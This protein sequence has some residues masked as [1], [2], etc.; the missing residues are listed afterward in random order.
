LAPFI[1][2]QVCTLHPYSI[3]A[4]SYLS[5]R[6]IQWLLFLLFSPGNF[7]GSILFHMLLPSQITIFVP[8][9]LLPVCVSVLYPLYMFPHSVFAALAITSEHSFWL[10]NHT[11]P[12]NV[13]QAA[14][15]Y[16]KSSAAIS[17]S[18]QIQ[19][20][21]QN[22]SSEIPNIS[23]DYDLYQTHIALSLSDIICN[24]LLGMSPAT[25]NWAW[26]ILH[27]YLAHKW[28]EL[29]RSGIRSWV[30]GDDDGGYINVLVGK[31]V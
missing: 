10:K 31:P 30:G 4:K 19:T 26:L 1:R 16:V 25:F 7:H 2:W 18:K 6:K 21:F 15:L 24:N 8:S 20:V 5:Y 9:I 28:M 14:K 17:V 27:L 11:F 23:Q 29:S 3:S 22:K 13:K 12:S